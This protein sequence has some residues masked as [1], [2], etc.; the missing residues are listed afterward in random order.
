[1]D[2]ITKQTPIIER[3]QQIK[4]TSKEKWLTRYSPKTGRMLAMTYESQNNRLES[5]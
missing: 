3:Y 2:G 5:A 4:F 1:M